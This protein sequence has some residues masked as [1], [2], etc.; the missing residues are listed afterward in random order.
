MS[1]ATGPAGSS[2]R[3][4]RLLNGREVRVRIISDEDYAACVDVAHENHRWVYGIASGEVATLI[5]EF[6]NGDRAEEP[7][8]PEW[9]RE[10]FVRLEVD[11]R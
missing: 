11:W 4:L 3:D 8:E 9:M 10:V 2:E 5:D 1:I 7:S 6:E